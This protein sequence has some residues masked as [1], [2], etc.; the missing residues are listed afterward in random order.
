MQQ[1]QRVEIRC[2]ALHRPDGTPPRAERH[3]RE[4]SQESNA[5]QRVPSCG[6]TA[7]VRVRPQP[8]PPPSEVGLASRLVALVDC[9]ARVCSS[10]LPPLVLV[11]TLSSAPPSQ[12]IKY[13]TVLRDIGLLHNQNRIETKSS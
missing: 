2:T 13:N 10:S 7:A 8:P 3:G 6:P 1:M 9:F 5:W 4:P 11:L 12:Y